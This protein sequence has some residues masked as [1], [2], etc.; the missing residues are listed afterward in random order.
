VR[1]LIVVVVALASLTLAS[2]AEAHIS[3]AFGA[4]AAEAPADQPSAHAACKSATI[5]GRHKCIQAGQYCTHSARA[6]RD[7]HR[8]GYHCGKRDRRGS[9][10]LIYY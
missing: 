7:Y 5:L 1:K 10:H 6:N 3:V 2:V 9:Y 4:P 8:Y